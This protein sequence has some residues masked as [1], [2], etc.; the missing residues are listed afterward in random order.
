M[1]P[2]HHF[3]LLDGKNVLDWQN[4]S[5]LRVTTL[6]IF[7]LPDRLDAHLRLEARSNDINKPLSK[8]MLCHS[9]GI[10]S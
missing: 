3:F 8:G 6:S 5:A 1:C 7:D 4:N 10:N 2:N 9:A